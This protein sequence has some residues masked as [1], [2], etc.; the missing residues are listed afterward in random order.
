MRYLAFT[1]AAP[2]A[3]FGGVAVGERRASADRPAKSAVLGL[4]AGAL[5]LTRDEVDTHRA[6]ADEL[7]YAVR[8]EDPPRAPNRLMAD[9]HTAQTRAA[10]RKTTFA[11]RREQL[12][13][14]SHALETILSQREYR[15]D[16]CFTALLWTKLDAPRFSLEDVRNALTVPAFTPYLGRKSC[17]LSLPMAP[18]IIDADTTLSA[19]S[20]YDAAEP[21]D[22]KKF[23]AARLLT[24]KPRYA[25]LEGDTAGLSNDARIETRRDIPL[26]RKRWQ[27]GPRRET[28]VS[29]R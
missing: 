14:P 1:L 29:F 4:V 13:V 28:V 27:F 8:V 7:L 5:G 23:R 21:E 26:D 19:F 25:A 17:P 9:Y 24:T 16:V 15:T 6:L 20:V 3:A 12:A 22:A 10:P 18:R 2:L 11:T